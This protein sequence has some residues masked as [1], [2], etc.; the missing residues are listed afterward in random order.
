MGYTVRTDRYR[1]TEWREEDGAGAVVGVEL[2]DHAR[3][4]DETV[5]R[6]DQPDYTADRQAM[7]SVLAQQWPRELSSQHRR[8]LNAKRP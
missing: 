4:P 8:N 3:D 1:Y 2:Y 6:A 5:N 7:A